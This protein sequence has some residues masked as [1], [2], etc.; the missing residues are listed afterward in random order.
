[1]EGAYE[2]AEKLKQALP[3]WQSLSF[4]MALGLTQLF[5]YINYKGEGVDKTVAWVY[6]MLPVVLFIYLTMSSRYNPNKYSL[7]NLQV[8]PMIAFGLLGFVMSWAVTLIV[9][10]YA[11]GG[12]F[13]NVSIT[14]LWGTVLTQVLFVACSEELCFRYIL[15]AYLK[16][17]WSKTWWIVPIVISQA[18]FALFHW[19][20]YGGSAF[21]LLIAFVFGMIMYGAYHVKLWKGGP[22]LGLGFTIGA[23]AAYN[24][25]LVGVLAGAPH[26]TKLLGGG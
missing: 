7:D 12:T 18:S 4:F 15:P 21:S 24:L 8:V 22:N 11:M 3:H 20:V 26:I 1:M 23:H 2:Q 14:S 13:G 25:V 17:A 19:G 9:V 16:G 10:G 5:V 6:I